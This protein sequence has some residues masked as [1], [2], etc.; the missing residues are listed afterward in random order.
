MGA[1]VPQHDSGPVKR[2]DIPPVLHGLRVPADHVRY[3]KDGVDMGQLR[4][5]QG[6]SKDM[7]QLAPGDGLSHPVGEFAGLQDA[8]RL[9]VLHV[10]T[11][12]GLGGRELRFVLQGAA[13]DHGG[14]L[15][16]LA[17]PQ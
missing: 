13:A 16:R 14:Q 9:S 11:I 2:Q 12:P 1:G 17:D 6:G 8:L 15:H 3:G 10:G 7:G 5:R 4:F